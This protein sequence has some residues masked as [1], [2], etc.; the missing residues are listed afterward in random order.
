MAKVGRPEELT[1]LLRGADPLPG[2]VRR[3]LAELVGAHH[4]RGVQSRLS[5][6]EQDFIRRLYREAFSN[7]KLYEQLPNRDPSKPAQ[8]HEIKK[9]EYRRMLAAMFS[10]SAGT[11]R[12][13]IER[14]KTFAEK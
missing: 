3:W 2:D 6:F 10:V 7:G 12:D 13:V 1:R 4:R 9:G 14:R 8:V 11:I 5:I